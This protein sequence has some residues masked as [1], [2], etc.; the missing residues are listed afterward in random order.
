[1][2]LLIDIGNTR[3]KWQYR[4]LKKIIFSGDIL[5][6]NFMD[7]NFS[8]INSLEKVLV[9]NVNHKIVLEK[10]KKSLEIFECPLVEVDAQSTDIMINDYQNF[11]QL[12]VDRWL[13]SLGGWK[14]YKKP[15]LVV[16]AGTAITIDLID[17][18]E[19]KK[20]HFKGGMIL[21]GI[22]ITLAMLNNSTNLIDAEVGDNVFPSINTTDAV[23]TGIFKSILGAIKLVGKK[24]P[25]SFPILL[26]GGDA[27]VIYNHIDDDWKVRIMLEDG[28]IFDGLQI[29]I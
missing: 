19:N 12:G 24:Y 2:Y 3:I 10:I 15:L 1:M 8:Q 25:S 21:P 17:I 16:N 13:A 5:V 23:T 14:R 11:S 28:L 7:I 6:E 4:D 18:D 27:S 9:A 26:T 29:Y 22:A 20:F